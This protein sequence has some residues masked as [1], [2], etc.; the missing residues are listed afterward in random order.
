MKNLI[1]RGTVLEHTYLTPGMIRIVFGGEGL[2]AFETSGIGDEYLRLYFPLPDTGEL[3][4]PSPTDP[5]GEEDA[6]AAAV[7]Y[8]PA[9]RYTVR[10]FDPERGEL[11]VDFV[12]HDGGIASAWALAAAPGAELGIGSP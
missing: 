11:T 12:V 5:D 6:D 1:H 3:V 2:R 10:R 8:S 7:E 4:L 9:R